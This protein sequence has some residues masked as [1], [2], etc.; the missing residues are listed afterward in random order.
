[1]PGRH[2]FTVEGLSK[3]AAVVGIWVRGKDMMLVPVEV[4]EGEQLHNVRI[5]VSEM[6]TD[7]TGVVRDAKGRPAADALVLAMPPGAPAWSTVDARFQATRTD[8]DGRYRISGLPPGAYRIAA[9]T[10]SDELAAW[11][12]EWFRRVDPHAISIS[13]GA[14]DKRSADLVAVP[15]DAVMPATT[16]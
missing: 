2:Y 15:V 1:M 16:R 14:A 3:P 11:R 10:G 6:V 13:L 8:A 7:L 5:V 4:G 12:P 9:L